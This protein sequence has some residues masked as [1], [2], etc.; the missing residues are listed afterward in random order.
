MSDNKF[1]FTEVSNLLEQS[2]IN[3]T[4]SMNEAAKALEKFGREVEDK[5]ID[6]EQD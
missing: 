5:G 2:I 1:D 6:D 4:K 3:F